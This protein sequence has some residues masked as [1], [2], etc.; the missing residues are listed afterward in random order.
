ML[1]YNLFV[2]F[3]S[4]Q[5]AT[6]RKGAEFPGWIDFLP[7]VGPGLLLAVFSL[8]GGKGAAES[9][10]ARV[11]LWMWMAVVG[12]I[13]GLRPGAFAL[14]FLVGSGLP[15][16]VL[17]STALCRFPPDRTVLAALCLCTSAVAQ[18]RI[19]LS[20]DP[21]WFVP[22]ERLAVAEAL[23]PLCSDADRLLAPPDI[24]LYAMGLSSCHVVVAHPVASD[25]ESRVSELREFYSSTSPA[26]R[27]AMLDRDRV[28]YV[29]LPGDAGPRAET[30]LG[31]G[32]PFQLVGR[33]SVGSGLI[34]I[35][36]RQAPR[37]GDTSS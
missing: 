14:Q 16:M 6:F 19:M 3:G 27:L 32:A 9:S 17:A 31:P 22:R 28:T 21:N 25:Y 1:G 24:S 36:V 30:W 37:S 33:T 29:V 20:G 26:A 4:S 18:T 10:D 23:R 15:L 11:H 34:S 5:F 2:F 13:I 7:A 8:R 35:Y 12:A